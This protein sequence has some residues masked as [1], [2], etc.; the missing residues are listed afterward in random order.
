M[1]TPRALAGLVLIVASACTGKAVP[2]LGSES[3]PLVLN[4]DYRFLTILATND[5]HGSV[6]PQVDARTG[7]VYGGMALFGGM[8]KSTREGIRR[9]YGAQGGVLVLDGGDQFQ[10]TL[11]SNYTEGQLV[12][13]TMNLAGYDAIVPGNHDYDFGPEGW[14]EDRVTPLTDQNPRGVI[15]SLS[16]DIRFPLLSANTYFKASLK[17]AKGNPIDPSLVAGSGCRVSG[18]NIDFSAAER[19][20][21][22]K[23]YVIKE[24][25]ITGLKIAIIGIDNNGTATLT[26]PENVSDLCFR[27]E[28]SEYKSIRAELE[29]QADIFILVI[30]SGNADKEETVSTLVSRLN[31]LPGRAVDAVIAG[32]THWVHNDN[33]D[34][35]RAIQSGA[36]GQLFGRI[37]LV[38]NVRTATVDAGQTRSFAGIRIYEDGCDARISGISSFCR[39]IGSQPYY[40]GVALRPNPDIA[41]AIAEQRRLIEPFAGRKLGV[42]EKKLTRDRIGESSTSNVLTDA[43]QKLAAAEG[44]QIAFMNTGGIRADINAGEVTYED[45][46]KVL[47]FNN[48]GV[49]IGPMDWPTLKK[50]LERSIATCG[51]YGSLMQSGL[52]V[53]YKRDC[54]RRG[55]ETVAVAELIRVGTTDGQVIFD[56]PARIAPPSDRT[57][58]VSTLDFL[59]AGGSGYSEF[60]GITTQ[61]KD[62]G[63]LREVIADMLALD[64]PQWQG[65]LDGRWLQVR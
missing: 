26:T 31:A 29:G 14:L 50:L 15:E 57:F 16:R 64:P 60:V 40:Q 12:F 55:N 45:L 46:F 30:H 22:L 8:V 28:F 32:H 63:I 62:I 42:A 27:D 3:Q 37:D 9:Q 7:K 1:R 56:S 36:N 38:Y 18:T 11:I 19:P 52:K 49:V 48:H 4:P 5:I 51:A 43:F 41:D 13:R 2:T 20:A 65:L 10:G 59:A 34:G 47:P 6:E 24:D 17:D 44:S 33:V 61:P 23:P 21:F 39:T 25:T 58:I 35:I 54:V 53:E